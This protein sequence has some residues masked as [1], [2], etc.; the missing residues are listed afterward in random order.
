MSISPGERIHLEQRLLF[1]QQKLDSV[2]AKYIRVKDD[3]E[4]TYSIVREL[5]IM[6]ERPDPDDANGDEQ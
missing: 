3:Y 5:L 6:L 1:W 4:T 2:K